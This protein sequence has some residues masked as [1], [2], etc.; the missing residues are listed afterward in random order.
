MKGWN[1]EALGRF[2]GGRQALEMLS[3]NLACP[4]G[5]MYSSKSQVLSPPLAWEAIWKVQTSKQALGR[6]TEN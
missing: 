2:R 5:S 6:P 3:G 4:W 1:Q